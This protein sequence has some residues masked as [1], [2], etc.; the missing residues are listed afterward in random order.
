[1]AT[2]DA[3]DEPPGDEQGEDSAELDAEEADNE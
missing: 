2:A 3:I 1:M